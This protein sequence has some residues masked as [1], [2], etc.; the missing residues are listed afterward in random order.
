MRDFVRRVQVRSQELVRELTGTANFVSIRQAVGHVI[1]HFPIVQNP[2]TQQRIEVHPQR[3]RSHLTSDRFPDVRPQ[4]SIGQQVPTNLQLFC[5]G[6]L[7]L[8]IVRP[9]ERQQFLNLIR[10]QFQLYRV[11][12]I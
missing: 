5:Q 10:Q 8:D 1:H 4:S 6:S 9:T 7:C 12:I 11:R 3:L 2:L